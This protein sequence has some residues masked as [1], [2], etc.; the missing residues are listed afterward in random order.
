MKIANGDIVPGT[1]LVAG[2]QTVVLLSS[3]IDSNNRS[4]QATLLQTR[5]RTL[6]ALSTVVVTYDS[7]HF[8]LNFSGAATGAVEFISGAAFED[9]IENGSLNSQAI[10]GRQVLAGSAFRYNGQVLVLSS[11]DIDSSSTSAQAALLETQLRQLTGINTLTVIY[12]SGNFVVT[13]PNDHS[14]AF[15]S[16]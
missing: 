6:T 16:L 4:T 10:P 15:L 11:S 7:T 14:P 3:D 2:G 13:F 5:L 9:A 1:I 8:F 12:S